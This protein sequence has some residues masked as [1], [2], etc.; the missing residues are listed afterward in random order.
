MNLKG[1]ETVGLLIKCILK[2]LDL[3]IEIDMV[4]YNNCHG[5]VEH[6]E[7]MSRSGS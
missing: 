5:Y 2:I 3:E 4:C 6:V 7:S 1:S